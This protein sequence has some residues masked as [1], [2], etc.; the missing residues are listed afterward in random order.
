[1]N[2][3]STEAPINETLKKVKVAVHLF[4]NEILWGYLYLQEDERLQDMMND[5]RMFIPLLKIDTKVGY[6]QQYPTVVINKQVIA[7]LEER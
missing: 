7:R 6:D 1:M 3:K 5:D 2:D 4:S